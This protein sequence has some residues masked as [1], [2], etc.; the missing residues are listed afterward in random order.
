MGSDGLG[1]GKGLKQPHGI[2]GAS[3][4][5]GR[6]SSL[7]GP[8]F[9]SILLSKAVVLQFLTAIWKGLGPKLLDLVWVAPL[10]FP[11]CALFALL[12]YRKWRDRHVDPP[13]TEKLLR[14]PGYS[15]SVKLDTYFDELLT[16]CCVTMLICAASEVFAQLT[17]VAVIL[18]AT[19]WV[20]PFAGLFFATALITGLR[21]IRTA[22]RFRE[23][24]NVRLGLRGEQAVAEAL[25]E[26]GD[27]GY[28]SFHDVE[29]K[30]GGWNIDHVVVGTRGIFLI[31]TKARRRRTPRG[32]QPRHVVTY[33]G[34]CLS[35][36]S[37]DDMKAVPQVERNARWLTDFLAK[38]TAEPVNVEGI[39]VVPGWYTESK[40]NYPVK[41]MNANYLV[42]F[43]R[44]QP[45]RSKRHARHRL[46]GGPRLRAGRQTTASCS[47]K[48][49]G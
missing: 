32:A 45:E 43:L 1:E 46:T 19:W 4:R 22:N 21:V 9:P 49:R 41:V 10:L 24:Q 20:L 34:R 14:P 11:G 47:S 27:C 44:K 29:P 17:G 6:H 28:R 3:N 30:A 15:L 2:R 35:F 36:P 33:D 7:T 8:L 13:Q 25:N 40:G 38:K 37:G 48:L 39:I 5:Y 23:M 26:A 42:K 18:A 12:Y 16:D 31:Q